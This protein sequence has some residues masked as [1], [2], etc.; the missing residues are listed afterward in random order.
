[1]FLLK[2]I[3]K[4]ALED[5]KLGLTKEVIATKALPFL[6]PLSIENGLTLK[7]YAVV[8]AL[9]RNMMD[10]VEEE[11]RV[12]L[13]QLNSLQAEQKSALQ[14]SMS[15]SATQRPGQL[16]PE[17]AGVGGAGDMFAG[18]GLDEYVKGKESAGSIATGMM[19]PASSATPAMPPPP[20]RSVSPSLT[21]LSLEEKRRVMQQSDQARRMLQ[22]Q[23]PGGAGGIMSPAS[24]PQQPG[25]PAAKDLTQS[26]MERNLTQ[27]KPQQPQ[28]SLPPQQQQ[29]PSSSGGWGAFTGTQ[30]Q[31]GMT[32]MGSA[33]QGMFQATPQQVRY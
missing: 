8:M 22:Q 31:P 5:D 19:S 23:Q 21:S 4:L 12:K 9:I 13:D 2:G 10:R 6:F 29:A 14:V 32:M 17:G 26:L 7:Q 1:M 11:H 27:M 30:Q 18:L 16:V 3:Y 20:G 28:Y 33:Q 15:E 24:A 25:K